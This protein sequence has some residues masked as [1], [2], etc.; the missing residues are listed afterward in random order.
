MTSIFEVKKILTET[1]DLDAS[2][3]DWQLDS[4]LLGA[5]P[6]LN[7]LAVVAVI[8]ALE[9]RFGISIE[10]DEIDAEMFETLGS[11][12]AM[13]DQKAFPQTKVSMGAG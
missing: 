4:L 11:L 10:D 8:T 7:S 3:V 5:V 2:N 9:E 13:I 12:V 1:L 6:E